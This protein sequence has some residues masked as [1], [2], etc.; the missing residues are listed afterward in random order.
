M[1]KYLTTIAIVITFSTIVCCGS[2]YKSQQHD[3]NAFEAKYCVLKSDDPIDEKLPNLL[4]I[5]T[6]DNRAQHFKVIGEKT[7]HS[8]GDLIIEIVNVYDEPIIPFFETG[9]NFGE[10][11]GE[12]MHVVVFG[13]NDKVP[14]LGSGMGTLKRLP[15]CV[16]M[17]GQSIQTTINFRTCG[18]W[19]RNP[20]AHKVIK[21]LES[22]CYQAGIAYAG[23]ILDFRFELCAH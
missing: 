3:G 15:N 12:N 7:I 2:K 9:E 18:K 21:S 17:P 4:R 8:R 10:S 19:V 1:N 20:D 13:M 22:G 23:G 5:T 14:G 16:L 11:M 6:I